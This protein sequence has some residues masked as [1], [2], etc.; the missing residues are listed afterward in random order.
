MSKPSKFDA[1][2][3]SHLRQATEPEKTELMDWARLLSSES[4]AKVASDRA[5]TRGAARFALIQA[6]KDLDHFIVSGKRVADPLREARTLLDL[7]AVGSVEGFAAH[8]AAHPPSAG[9]IAF[10]LIE[11]TRLHLSASGSNAAKAFVSENDRPKS[12]AAFAT[13]R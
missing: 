9:C 8:I 7:I 4:L 12:S 1:R 13:P 10:L 6:R 2:I 11:N 3:S 5:T